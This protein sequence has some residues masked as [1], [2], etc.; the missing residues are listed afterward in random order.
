MVQLTPHH[1]LVAEVGLK[2]SS[3][4]FSPL[5]PLSC[6]FRVRLHCTL[7]RNSSLN[8]IIILYVNTNT[9]LQN[10]TYMLFL[11]FGIT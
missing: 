3:L 1:Y 5:Q 9:I 7:K 6:V 2:P 4:G 10:L 8:R 11:L